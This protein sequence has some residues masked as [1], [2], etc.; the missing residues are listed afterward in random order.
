MG[1][2]TFKN[3][4]TSKIKQPEQIFNILGFTICSEKYKISLNNNIL[5]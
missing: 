4:F 5:Q 3:Y 2:Y 1:L